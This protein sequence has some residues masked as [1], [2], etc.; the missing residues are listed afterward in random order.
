MI[1]GKTDASKNLIKI[2]FCGRNKDNI[3]AKT[4]IRVPKKPTAKNEY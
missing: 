2:I 4:P 1:K 3:F